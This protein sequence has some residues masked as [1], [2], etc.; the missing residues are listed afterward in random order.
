MAK[1][2]KWDPTVM[3]Q[4]LQ[5]KVSSNDSYALKVGYKNQDAYFK[6][7]EDATASLLHLIQLRA[8]YVTKRRGQKQPSFNDVV[9]EVVNDLHTTQ[10]L[11]MF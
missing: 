6:A 1:T 11:A 5:D 3:V 9:E 2:K 4:E 7:K 8:E 10:E